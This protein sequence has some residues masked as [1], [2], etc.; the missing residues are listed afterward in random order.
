MGWRSGRRLA[1]RFTALDRAGHRKRGRPS[2]VGGQQVL[3]VGVAVAVGDGV[4]HGSQRSRGV[5][6]FLH[7]REVPAR[8]V[9]VSN[10]LVPHCAVTLV[11]HVGNTVTITILG[12]NINTH[13]FISYRISCNSI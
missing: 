13:D 10:A 4:L 3:P 2:V 7:R 11:Y 8:V 12:L 9:G 5:G 1:R 6:V